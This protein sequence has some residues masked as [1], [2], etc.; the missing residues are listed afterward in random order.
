MTISWPL[1]LAAASILALTIGAVHTGGQGRRRAL[2]ASALLSALARVPAPAALAG[3]LGVFPAARSTHGVLARLGLGQTALGRARAGAVVLVGTA[4]VVSAA[5]VPAAIPVL[6]VIP[7]A[8]I[9]VPDALSAR[10]TRERK[11]QLVDQL[12]DALDLLA[13]SARAGMTLDA[14]ISLVADRLRGPF[15]EEFDTVRRALELGASRRSALRALADRTA[16]EPIEQ[17][18]SALVRA[19][20]LGAPVAG[21]LERLARSMRHARSQQ[22]RE[23]AAKAA[24]KIQL[25][26]A[27]LM[28]PATLMLVI[29]LL[30]IEL[31]RQVNAVLGTG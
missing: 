4:A 16:A 8:A 15:Q 7:V 13:V 30:L 27:L 26:V 17:L 6:L 14:A 2:E 21:T 3:S 23:R 20:E 31:T 22:A 28:V 18:C 10:A 5:V 12:P 1:A 25:V 24:P 9:G 29:G 11:R 19:D